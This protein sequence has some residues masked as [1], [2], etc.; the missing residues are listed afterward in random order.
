MD[1]SPSRRNAIQLRGST[2]PSDESSSAPDTSGSED[3]SVAVGTSTAG[4]TAQGNTEDNNGCESTC[5]PLAG[6]VYAVLSDSPEGYYIVTCVNVKKGAF[7][8]KYLSS[9]SS[10]D[11]ER[12]CFRE[13]SNRDTFYFETVVEE[14]LSAEHFRRDSLKCISLL[15]EELNDIIL[16]VAEIEDA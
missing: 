1:F 9:V 3:T 5:V 14:I 10:S 2:L 11:P 8:G 13:T 4:G 6:K 16:T 7:T 15:K 12:E